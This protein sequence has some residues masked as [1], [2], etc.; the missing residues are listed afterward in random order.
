MTVKRFHNFLFFISFKKRCI[1]NTLQILK[2]LELA[3]LHLPSFKHEIYEWSGDRMELNMFNLCFLRFNLCKVM[4]WNIFM[5]KT[6]FPFRGHGSFNPPHN[7][8]KLYHAYEL[9]CFKATFILIMVE[10]F[11]Y[12]FMNQKFTEDG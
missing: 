10:F 1:H 3:L 9:I 6:S 12:L 5:C 8:F 4:K 11:I 2:S 7:F